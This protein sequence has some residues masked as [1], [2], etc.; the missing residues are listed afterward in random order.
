MIFRGF[1][2]GVEEI[3]IVIGKIKILINDCEVY[4]V[5]FFLG[6]KNKSMWYN[7]D[8]SNKNKNIMLFMDNVLNENIIFFG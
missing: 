8:K 7:L 2:N 3:V 5:F 4:L 1:F 6:E